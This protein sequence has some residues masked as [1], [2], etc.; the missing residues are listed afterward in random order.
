MQGFLSRDGMPPAELLALGR[1]EVTG[2]GVEIVSGTV[3]AVEP[4]FVVRLADGR[5]VIARRIL[6]TTGVRDDLPDIPGVHERWGR[7]LLHCPYC[8]GWEVRDQP[9]GVL[10]S[11]PA[12]AAHAQLVRQWS[13]DVVFFAH[14]TDVSSADRSQLAGR[15][16]RVVDGEVARLVVVDDALVG[17]ELA[18]GSVV[19]RSAVFVRP[20]NVPHRDGL[21][22]QLGVDV[23]A[24]GF[25][26]VDRDGHTSAPGVFAA[27]N[28]VDPRASVVAAAG[29]A[30][31][32]AMAIN[33]DLVQDDVRCAVART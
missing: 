8:H 6:L 15:G 14:T 26:E 32:A 19:P 31:T 9:L 3:A 2:Y 17:V 18:D 30:A 24:E 4:G 28:L 29:A 21:L 33:A 12:A 16:I 7:D 23:T 20:R 25:A 10:G 27:G 5:A 22:E 13:D 1:E 11:H